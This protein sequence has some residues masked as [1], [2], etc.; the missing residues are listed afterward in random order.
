MKEFLLQIKNSYDGSIA[1]AIE[2]N[3]LLELKKYIIS[4]NIHY[5]KYTLVI[6]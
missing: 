4:R 6:Q 5:K 2:E 1:L 3:V